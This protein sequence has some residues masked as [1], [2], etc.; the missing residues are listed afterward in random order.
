[1]TYWLF[2]GAHLSTD[3]KVHNVAELSHLRPLKMKLNLF[4]TNYSGLLKC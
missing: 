1:M 3:D 2:H 4:W